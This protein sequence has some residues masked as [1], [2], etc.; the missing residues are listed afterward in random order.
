M[1]VFAVTT[2]RGPNW[3]HDHGIREQP[4]WEERAQ[5]FDELVKCG[6]ILLGG[7]I[8]SV[9]D[10]EVGLLAVEAEDETALQ[11]IFG[12]DPW[13]TSG[14]LRVKEIRSWLRWLDGR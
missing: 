9:G 11:R 10:D 7:P 1:A 8:S 13:A 12:E 4:A 3:R 2:A 5:F 6:V 14:V